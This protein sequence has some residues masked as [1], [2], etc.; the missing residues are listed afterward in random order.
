MGINNHQIKE[1]ICPS[2]IL[3][4]CLKIKNKKILQSNTLVKN[5]LTE[6]GWKSTALRS[7]F[8]QSKEIILCININS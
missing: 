3:D 1:E 7:C 4:K 6:K 5:L 8:S 2:P